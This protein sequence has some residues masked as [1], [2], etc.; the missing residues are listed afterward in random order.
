MGLVTK[1]CSMAYIYRNVYISIMSH[2]INVLF[3][4]LLLINNKLKIISIDKS[5]H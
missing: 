2:I 4:I 3:D 5:L 1:I